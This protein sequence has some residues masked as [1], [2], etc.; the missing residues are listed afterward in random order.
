MRRGQN[1][2][3]LNLIIFL[4]GAVGTYLKRFIFNIFSVYGEIFYAP[5]FKGILMFFGN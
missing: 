3:H 5:I 2:A 4:L 1:V